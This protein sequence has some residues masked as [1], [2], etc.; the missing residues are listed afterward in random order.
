MKLAKFVAAV[1]VSFLT[2][3][4]FAKVAGTWVIQMDIP[5]MPQSEDTA[6]TLTIEVDDEGNHS[7]TLSGRMGESM[8]IDAIDVDEGE[9]SFDVSFE[10]GGNSMTMTY[11]GTVEDGEMSGTV[12]MG[13]GE[14]SQEFDFTGE[15][16]EEDEEEAGDEEAEEEEAAE[17]ATEDAA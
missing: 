6:Q 5:Q 3:S 10:M 11:K 15:P 1:T 16:K 2:V 13:S 7:G 12:S 9:F 8:E 17:E 4:L 14:W